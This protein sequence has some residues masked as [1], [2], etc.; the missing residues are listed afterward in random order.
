MPTKTTPAPEG[1]KRIRNY[2][3]PAKGSAEA[4]ERMARVRAAQY[5]KN[6]LQ[7]TS[8]DKGDEKP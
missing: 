4:K 2:N 6:G 3:G 8:Q 1:F 5:A 7:Y